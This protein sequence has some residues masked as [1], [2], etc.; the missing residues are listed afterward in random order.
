ML[1]KYL[2]VAALGSALMTAPAL[3]QTNAMSSGNASSGVIA[4]MSSMRQYSMR[5]ASAEAA[6][7][8]KR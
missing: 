1:T 5:A 4:S 6:K 3:A 2:A 8:G 7:A